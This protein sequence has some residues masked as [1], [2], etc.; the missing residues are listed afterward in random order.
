M[1]TSLI[2]LALVIAAASAAPL[3]SRQTAVEGVV[4]NTKEFYSGVIDGLFHFGS[5]FNWLGCILD[6]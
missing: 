5:D 1:K 3:L 4:D 6:L 2:A